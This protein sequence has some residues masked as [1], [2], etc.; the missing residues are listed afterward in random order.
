MHTQVSQFIVRVKIP[1]PLLNISKFPNT[2]IPYWPWTDR[3]TLCYL[4]SQTK[5][6]HI[7]A[8]HQRYNDDLV[9][10]PKI[11]RSLNYFYSGGDTQYNEMK[12]LLFP[13]CYSNR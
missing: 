11:M 10:L 2:Y 4:S 3:H 5:I 9:F 13:K 1:D 6:I 7:I 8:P 12:L